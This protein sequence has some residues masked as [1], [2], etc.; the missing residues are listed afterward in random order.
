MA[1]IL[2]LLSLAAV[3]IAQCPD[4][5]KFSQK[6]HEPVSS[7]R[8]ALSYQRPEMAC[9]TFNSSIVETTIDSMQG[10]IKDPD[11]FRLFQ[12]SYPNSLDTA[13]KWK[14][15]ADG[16]DEELTFLITGDM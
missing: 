9:R 6:I 12:N 16:T 5:S 11:M 8:Y 1:L 10:V 2:F 15:F 4:Y 3:V 13:V 7:G 14:G